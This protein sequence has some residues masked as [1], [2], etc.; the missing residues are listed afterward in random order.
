MSK[1]AHPTRSDF[2]ALRR[3]TNALLAGAEKEESL[4]ALDQ[5]EKAAR[6]GD[7]LLQEMHA[8]TAREK[9]QRRLVALFLTLPIA[10]VPSYFAISMLVDL[11]R[12]SDEPVVFAVE[13]GL[14][15]ITA[16]VFLYTALVPLLTGEDASVSIAGKPPAS[17]RRSPLD[18]RSG[19]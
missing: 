8:R 6:E 12:W 2:E 10:C 19:P 9:A 18:R 4:V 11:A 7:R 16:L 3:D 13:F 1:Q 15:S 5:L 17:P 14:F